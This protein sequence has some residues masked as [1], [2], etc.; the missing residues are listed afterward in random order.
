MA[1]SRKRKKEEERMTLVKKKKNPELKY[2]HLQE[3]GV[4]H[5]HSNMEGGFIPSV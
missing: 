4:S 3:G 5:T 1:V 2:L